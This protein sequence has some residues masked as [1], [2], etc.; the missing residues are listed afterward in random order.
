LQKLQRGKTVLVQYP[1]I[2]EHCKMLL[3][4][5]VAADSG[6]ESGVLIR[7]VYAMR[8]ARKVWFAEFLTLLW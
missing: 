7:P 2:A 3:K 5:R 1:D 6:I 8:A 4:K